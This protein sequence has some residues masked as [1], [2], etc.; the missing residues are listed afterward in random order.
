MQRSG[1]I[2]LALREFMVQGG[3]YQ[4]VLGELGS[5]QWSLS[6]FS[7]GSL[8]LHW[9]HLTIVGV[10]VS[11]PERRPENESVCLLRMAM[12]LTLAKR[13]RSHEDS[14]AMSMFLK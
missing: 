2:V 12:H 11:R 8:H 3:N 14:H 9:R 4:T 1:H 10:Q 7:Q 13:L 5:R 6:Q